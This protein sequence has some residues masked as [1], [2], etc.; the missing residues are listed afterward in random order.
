VVRQERIALGEQNELPPSFMEAV[1]KTYVGLAEKITGQPL[2][3]ISD[4]PRAEIIACLRD[5]FGL[6]D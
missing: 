2:P 3:A 6:I 4:D 1:S 5:E